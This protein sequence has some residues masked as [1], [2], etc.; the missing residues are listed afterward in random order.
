MKR[1]ERKEKEGDGQSPPFLFSTK[2]IINERNEAK[3]EIIFLDAEVVELEKQS[4]N[5]SQGSRQKRSHVTSID[6]KMSNKKEKDCE[7]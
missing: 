3:E 4:K 1:N 5:L 7:E 2:W 6:L